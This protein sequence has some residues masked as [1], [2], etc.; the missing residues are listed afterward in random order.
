M[1]E[2][3]IRQ[4]VS[5]LTGHCAPLRLSLG[6]QKL[7]PSTDWFLACAKNANTQSD[8]TSPFV[9]APTVPPRTPA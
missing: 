3:A 9:A 5:S 8:L 1:P 2:E 6:T 7:A 4:V